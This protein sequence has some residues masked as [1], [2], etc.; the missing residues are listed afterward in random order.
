MHTKSYEMMKP[1]RTTITC[2]TIL[3]NIIR[4][5]TDTT[6]DEW[7]LRWMSVWWY[8]LQ[9]PLHQSYTTTVCGSATIRQLNIS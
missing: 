2:W 7:P 1:E 5:T 3:P 6:A 4:I 9:L 8:L